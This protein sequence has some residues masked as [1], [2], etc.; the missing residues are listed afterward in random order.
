[1]L[2]VFTSKMFEKHLWKSDIL[3]ENEGHW[4]ASLLKMSLFH[5]C[6]SNIFLKKTQIPGF[7]IS[8]TL[9]EN[10]SKF[11]HDFTKAWTRLFQKIYPV[12]LGIKSPRGKKSQVNFALGFWD[13]QNVFFFFFNWNSPGQPVELPQ[14]LAKEK[15]ASH[16]WCTLMNPVAVTII[17][18]Y[19]LKV[20]NDEELHI[21]D[22]S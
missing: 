21:L 14:E 8:E 6:F 16:S 10:W 1:M 11:N 20:F 18:L 17:M 12:F 5:G 15:T 13:L 22:V 7:Y 9:V 3:S 2:L 4:P 19:L